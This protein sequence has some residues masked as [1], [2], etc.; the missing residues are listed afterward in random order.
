MPWFCTHLRYLALKTLTDKYDIV[1]EVVVLPLQ[2]HSN[3][4]RYYEYNINIEQIRDIIIKH[5]DDWFR[6]SPYDHVL[7]SINTIHR[8][9]NIT[10]P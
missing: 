10:Q 8:Y 5:T 7:T 9:I 3:I 6:T 2:T 1:F 4:A